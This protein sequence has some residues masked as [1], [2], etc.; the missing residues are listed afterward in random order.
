MGPDGRELGKRI[1]DN[2]IAV[3]QGVENVRV[4]HLWEEGI[5][6]P[7]AGYLHESI[8][9]TPT[10]VS[11]SLTVPPGSPGADDIYIVGSPATGAWSGHEDEYAWYEDGSWEFQEPREG[12]LVWISD[13]PGYFGW[14][15]TAWAGMAGPG[16]VYSHS[17]LSNLD[18]DDH[19]QYALLAG[20]TGGQLFRGGDAT[21]DS[22][23]LRGTGHG[24]NNGS[25][26]LNDLGGNVLVG[27]GTPSNA[28][29]DGDF[30]V[31]N[32]LESDGIAYLN[33]G[34]DLNS[35]A[36]IDLANPSNPQD[37]ATKA[38]VDSVA[39]GLDWQDSV[40]DKDQTTPPG[41]ESGGER[42]IV[43]SPATGAWLGEDDNIAEYN[44][45]TWD[46]TTVNEGMATW[47]EDENIIYVYNGSAWVKFGAAVSHSN[48]LDLDADDHDQYFLLA[49]RSG[50]QTAYGG[51]AADDILSLQGSSDGADFGY[52]RIGTSGATSHGLGAVS[53]SLLVTGRFETVAGQRF[54][55]DSQPLFTST[56]PGVPDFQSGFTVWAGMYGIFGSDGIGYNTYQTPDALTIELSTTSRNVIICDTGDFDYDFAHAQQ[57]N[58]TL[59][60]QSANQS[61]TEWISFAHDGSDGRLTTGV[62]GFHFYTGSVDGELKI[63]GTIADDTN[64]QA[65]LVHA[66][67]DNEEE[68][69]YIFGG[70]STETTSI[71]NFGGGSGLANC[72]TQV[73]F[74]TAADNVTTTGVKRFRFWE[75]GRMTA[76]DGIDAARTAQLRVEQDS[77]TDGYVLD[78]AN[79]DT[80]QSTPY[81]RTVWSLSRTGDP[82]EAAAMR[83]VKNDTWAD[84]STMDSQILFDVMESGVL[85]TD[86]FCIDGSGNVG[87]GTTS[88]TRAL[89]ILAANATQ[90]RIRN[91]DSDN[92]L[93]NAYI[94]GGHYDNEEQDV[95]VLLLGSAST[96]STLRLG[97]GSGS[98]NAVTDIDF[99]TAADNKTT[100]GTRRASIESTGLVIVGRGTSTHSL[101]DEDLLCSADLEVIGTAYLDGGTTIGTSLLL[102]DD[103]ELQFGDGPDSYL[104]WSTAQATANIPV[105]G[106]GT[107]ATS[108]GYGFVFTTAANRNKDHHQPIGSQP[109]LSVFS[110]SDVD[111]S[112]AEY[113]RLQFGT[114]S[115]GSGTLTLDPAGDQVVFPRGQVAAPSITF[116]GHPAD[117]LFHDDADIHIVKNGASVMEFQDTLIVSA[118][119]HRLPDN[120]YSTFGNA[121]DARMFWSTA[122]TTDALMIG[123]GDS[124]KCL[125]ISDKSDTVYDFAHGDQTNPT[126]FIHSANQSTT[127][128]MSLSMTGSSY[129]TIKTGTGGIDIDAVGAVRVGTPGGGNSNHGMSSTGDLYLQGKLEVDDAAHFDATVYIYVGSVYGDNIAMQMG[130]GQPSTVRWSA[131]Q[132]ND[133]IV[134]GSGNG[135]TKGY[136]F[137]FDTFANRG[138][139]H[140]L[141]L[142]GTIN[143]G[144]F[145]AVFS[146]TDVD[147]DATEYT[148]VEYGAIT[149]GKGPLQLD[150]ATYVH[151]GSTGTPGLADSDGDLYVYH[152]LE[153]DGIA[154]FD[155]SVNFNSSTSGIDH[156]ELD[157]TSLTH[158]DHSG[159]W[160]LTGRTGNLTAYGST[161]ASGTLTID[162]TSHATPGT[163]TLQ[164]GG[165]AIDAEAASQI[166]SP[167]GTAAAPGLVIDDTD[168][169]TGFFEHSANNIGI[170]TGGVQRGR[171]NYLGLIIDRNN[172]GGTFSDAASAALDLRGPDQ[173][174]LWLTNSMAA[175]TTKRAEISMRSFTDPTKPITLFRGESTS[176]TTTNFEWGGGNATS[177]PATAHYWFT[178]DAETNTGTWKMYLANYGQVTIRRQDEINSINDVLSLQH[179]VPG[180]APTAAI[181]VRQEYAMDWDT[182]NV[183]V[184]AQVEV[185]WAS[186][187]PGVSN[188]GLYRVE[189]NIDGSF[190]Q[191]FEA[192]GRN[193]RLGSGSPGTATGD[194]DVFVTNDLEVDGMSNL[195]AGAIVT[196]NSTDP[197][198]S[199]TQ[200]G[201]GIG[202]DVIGPTLGGSTIRMRDTADDAT[203]KYGVLGLGNYNNSEEDFAFVSGGGNAANVA[204][205][206]GGGYS[207]KNAVM[208]IG[209]Y[210]ASN[211]TTLVGTK[212][213]ELDKDGIWRFGVP[214]STSHSLTG[215][216]V[217]MADE[218][219][220]DG[221]T[222]LDDGLSVEGGALTFTG[223]AGSWTIAEADSALTQTG[224]G[225]VTMTGN[226]DA[227]NGLD[228]TGAGFTA[229]GGSALISGGT[230]TLTADASS[231][232]SMQSDSPLGTS[233]KI[234]AQ[235]AGAGAAKL[236][237]TADDTVELGDA[238]QNPA[239][240][241]VGTGQVTFAGAVK[242]DGATTST[243]EVDAHTGSLAKLAL[244]EAGVDKAWFSYS[245]GLGAEIKSV[246]DF[247]IYT[248]ATPTERMEITSAGVISLRGETNIDDGSADPTLNFR[249]SG[250]LRASIYHDISAD[251]FVIDTDEGDL[252]LTPATG[253]VGIG[254]SSPVVTLHLSTTAPAMRLTDTDTGTDC[255]IS[256][257]SSTGSMSIEVDKNGEASNSELTFYL[258][259]VREMAITTNGYVQMN[260]TLTSHRLCLPNNSTATEGQATAY[261]FNNS[262]SVRWK[263]NIRDLTPAE[264]LEAIVAMRPRR[265]RMK[266]ENGGDTAI[267]F[268][269]EELVNVLP[270][271]VYTQA[272]H[273]ENHFAMVAKQEARRLARLAAR[274]AELATAPTDTPKQQVRRDELKRTI[275]RLSQPGDYGDPPEDNGFS[276]SIAQNQIVPVC[277]AAIQ[278]LLA[279]VE[280]LEAQAA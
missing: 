237:L 273:R 40:L 77:T 229:I 95:M 5:G 266:P 86:L 98:L 96:T 12:D 171:W 197:A 174:L 255:Q 50:G 143:S 14:T 4:R 249:E 108:A 41:G 148:M 18:A 201:T 70:S 104:D 60:I 253:Q 181:G 118:K 133:C 44:G 187:N 38:Y 246:S 202:C 35:Q 258:D 31:T 228:V 226:L 145:L 121:D 239:I 185:K 36:I 68:P 144:P 217:W 58:P 211:T 212:W 139:N 274:R 208:K 243:L 173:N 160:W 278:E 71:M 109:Y 168:Q 224:S 262:S 244:Q 57:S 257:A 279:R 119:N 30:Y 103:I 153:V 82:A 19:D 259:T 155:G 206:L 125:I 182:D 122:Q 165:G 88:P 178:G 61:A 140:H 154:Q 32:K 62:G 124:S 230:I 204:M 94:Q 112:A 235:N 49:G 72:A 7:L 263:E 223:T 3:K 189:T 205:N 251:E 54:Y 92:T 199:I 110:A 8:H 256:G 21:G 138:K 195:E 67:Y 126:V 127:E 42:H 146:T 63:I 236:V 167:P 6:P 267:G 39:T 43:A 252:R 45:A 53:G 134:W 22:L 176:A 203:N 200:S 130:D 66:H 135:T 183:R 51:T 73:A 271:A 113:L 79:L 163:L 277:V 105:F 166:L 28:T 192:S 147:S 84:V 272:Q 27:D 213:G 276:I 156:G 48:L 194:D 46:F 90:L 116:T 245:A 64:K 114:I 222:Y 207:D 238:S 136:G 117:G 56:S 2:V 17:L 141:G 190:Y 241:Q 188:T 131:A 111:V 16:V 59:W 151:I 280:Q 34:A 142:G 169:N 193:I 152:D 150:P 20:R 25:I 83:V 101:T 216:Y 196:R 13:E 106:W 227:T 242:L 261:Q 275:A 74:W 250:T 91:T 75:D 158:D 100:T 180:M 1:F 115:T 225:Q 65:R 102:A 175:T 159:Y 47:V 219:E 254:T 268:I 247:E 214:G 172:T 26:Y 215:P 80:T 240:T 128:W 129:G 11:Q 264:G 248:G 161:D 234:D 218:L 78:L 198:A 55:C 231:V 37:A 184:A 233:L 137:I 186:L 149:T 265:Y 10:I 157:A 23:T 76:G 270:E 179:R 220:V 93:K 87:I 99:Y 29:G 209:F 15:G 269:G 232:W 260:C 107:G 164:S 24:D 191:V 162:A 132:D 221:H 81:V 123:V 33:A 9:V 97:G 177:Y 69:V 52:V 120:T 170:T 85:Q 210:T 89:D